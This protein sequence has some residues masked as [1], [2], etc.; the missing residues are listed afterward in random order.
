MAG[1]LA[2]FLSGQYFDN[3]GAPLVGGKVYAYQA[4][5][6]T[7]QATYTDSA[8]GTPNTNP[9]IL[10][11]SGAAEI[12]LDPS[13]SYKFVIKDSSD[14]TIR[15]RDNVVGLLTADAVNTASLQNLCVTTPKLALDSVDATILKDSA[16]VDGDRA[17]RRTISGTRTSRALS[18][19]PVPSQQKPSQRVR[20]RTTPRRTRMT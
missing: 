15:T 18:S 3:N 9:V 16:S 11:S 20:P 17:S 4:G 1:N 5:T 10:D 12:W 13:L 14:V 6:S 7:P 19:R 8:L 2:P